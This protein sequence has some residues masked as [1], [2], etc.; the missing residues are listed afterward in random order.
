M[1][2]ADYFKPPS[3]LHFLRMLLLVDED[4]IEPDSWYVL[5]I[6]LKQSGSHGE[7]CL[8]STATRTHTVIITMETYAL[9]R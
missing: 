8:L 4:R 2:N 9:D 6:R 7:L 3:R 5:F 1:Y